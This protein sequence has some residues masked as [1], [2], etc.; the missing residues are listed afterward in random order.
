MLFFE[1]V[2]RIFVDLDPLAKYDKDKKDFSP[3]EMSFFMFFFSMGDSRFRKGDLFFFSIKTR[4]TF[5]QKIR[6]DS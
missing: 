1:C 5:N 6:P 2:W 4:S 3:L